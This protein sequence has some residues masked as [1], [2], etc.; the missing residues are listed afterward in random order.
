MK[1][2]FVIVV[3]GGLV[4]GAFWLIT[5][6]LGANTFAIPGGLYAYGLLGGVLAAGAAAY[7]PDDID[8]KNHKRLLFVSALAGLSCPSVINTAVSAEAVAQIRDT[9]KKIDKS[10]GDVSEKL[11]DENASP[12]DISNSFTSM[13]GAVNSGAASQQDVGEVESVGR[14]ALDTLA[15]DADKNPDEYVK[16]IEKIGATT[17]ALKLESTAKLLELANSDNSAVAAA[18]KPAK[19]RNVAALPEKIQDAVSESEATQQTSTD[20]AS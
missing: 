4:G 9:S 12:G 2:D 3:F 10:V 14:Q 6:I 19:D 1:N 17:P 11:A 8:L 13:S 18:A 20:S 16:A 15:K 5:Q 7:I